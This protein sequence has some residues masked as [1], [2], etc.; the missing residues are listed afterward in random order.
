MTTATA[1]HS[2]FTAMQ[3]TTA[4]A[5]AT[6]TFSL[7]HPSFTRSPVHSPHQPTDPPGCARDR[8]EPERVV[9]QGGGQDPYGVR[10]RLLRPG[11]LDRPHVRIGARVRGVH[12]GA[13][14][15]HEVLQR[16]N[17]P[18]HGPDRRGCHGVAMLQAR[19]MP[20]FRG[21]GRPRQHS[22]GGVNWRHPRQLFHRDARERVLHAGADRKHRR[23]EAGEIR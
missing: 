5:T 19:R 10:V 22:G 9:V 17:G 18:V 2:T 13:S 8:R 6:P 11:E 21:P 7:A 4:T 20:R 23:D 1:T 12:Q 15:V 3:P 16:V 14:R